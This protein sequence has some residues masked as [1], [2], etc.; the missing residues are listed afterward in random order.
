MPRHGQ[1]IT[2]GPGGYD[3]LLYAIVA[4]A[5]EDWRH[6]AAEGLTHVRQWP[7][8]RCGAARKCMQDYRGPGQV[9]ELRHFISDT[10]GRLLRAVNSP[11]S[12]DAMVQR[13]GVS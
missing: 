4:Q 3:A 5:V 12:H 2:A 10:S 8:T 13:L 1:S 11:V 6:L 7:R 9:A